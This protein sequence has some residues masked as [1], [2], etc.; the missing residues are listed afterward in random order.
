MLRDFGAAQDLKLPI[1]RA[2]SRLIT[3]SNLVLV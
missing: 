2:A 1:A 3:H